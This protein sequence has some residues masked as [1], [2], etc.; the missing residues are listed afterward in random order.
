M[1]GVFYFP[2]KYIFLSLFTSIWIKNHFLLKAQLLSFFQVS[3]NFPADSLV[4]WI[5]ENK[6]VS[7]GKSLTLDDKLSNK[8]LIWIRNNNRPNIDSCSAPPLTL[9]QVDTWLLRTTNSFLLL[10]K[11]LKM[12]NKSPEIPFY[13]SLK[14]THSCQTLSKAL[15]TSKN[16]LLTSSPLLKNW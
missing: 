10:K 16:A 11:S 13:S 6:N 15:D 3:F 9:V 2:T 4:S 5:I 7:S 1:C 14:I 12:F 8:S